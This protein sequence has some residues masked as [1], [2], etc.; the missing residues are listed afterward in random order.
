MALFFPDF[1]TI[2]KLRQAPTDGEIHLLKKLGEILNDEY[3]IYFQSYVNGDRPDVLIMRKG[4]GVLI[5]EVKDWNLDS[6]DIDEKRNWWVKGRDGKKY[7]KMSPSNQALNYK[8]NLFNLHV[9]GLLERKIKDWKVWRVVN[10]VVYFHNTSTE[11]L[12]GFVEKEIERDK[13]D[14]KYRERY[15]KHLKYIDF[16]GRNGLTEENIKEICKKRGMDSR[17][18]LFDDDL[19]REFK[20]CFSPPIHTI[21]QGEKI[22]YSKEQTN[23]ILSKASSS[24]KVKGVAGSG[25][26]MCLAKRAVNAHKRH[27]KEVLILTYNITLRNYVKDKISEVREDFEWKYFHII[28]YHEFLKAEALNHGLGVTYWD[29]FNDENFFESVKDEIVKYETILIDEIQDYQKPWVNLV[30][31]YFLSDTGNEYVAYGDEKQNIYERSYNEID[32]KP[33]TKIGGQWNLLKKSFRVS[34]KIGRLAEEFQ[35]EFFKDKYEVD[36]ILTQTDLFDNSFI[37]YHKEENFDPENTAR[38]YRKI[39]KKYE[40]HKNDVCIQSTDVEPLRM[41]DHQLTQSDSV[42][43]KTTTM[44]EK[45]NEFLDI[46]KNQGLS[47]ND[48]QERFWKILKRKKA[49]KSLTSEEDSL[50][51]KREKA[52]ME[53]NKLRR[54]RKFH[55]RAN[56]GTVKISTIHSFKGWEVD[57]LI[58]L[59]LKPSVQQFI[60]LGDSGIDSQNDHQVTEE[61]IYTGITRCRRNLF[62]LNYGN[63]KFDSFFRKSISQV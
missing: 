34:S 24:Q 40:V 5:I 63:E 31:K 26:T 2:L 46:L 45:E 57:T 4:G 12:R 1:E 53:I 51:E 41:I 42:K 52:K 11:D 44:F 56:A 8:S 37:G 23:I 19:Y 13:K 14:K 43:E 33:Y 6:Y 30:L 36:E 59:I 25:K 10:C 21:E 60:D 29:S 15:E 32:K 48:Y 61:M 18:Q 58:L 22:T 38:L 16:L 9:K 50:L 54:N 49:G 27:G 20:G 17:N 3:E 39:V 28:H 55:F 7:E 35:K 62:I 47:K